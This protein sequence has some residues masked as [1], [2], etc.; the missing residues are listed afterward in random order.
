MNPLSCSAVFLS[1]LAWWKAAYCW[2]CVTP[3]RPALCCGF[4]HWS[5]HRVVAGTAAADRRT[6]HPPFLPPPPHRRSCWENPFSGLRG[7]TKWGVLVNATSTSALA[8]CEG[9]W[10]DGYLHGDGT[11]LCHSL[12]HPDEGHVVVQIIDGTLQK[13]DKSRGYSC[14]SWW[15]E[16]QNYYNT[17]NNTFSSK[18]HVDGIFAEKSI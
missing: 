18:K 14:Q 9:L 16:P 17:Q 7:Q 8:W 6:P 11:F 2:W 3:T 10:V 5:A 1:G 4:Q 13:K 12:V 15:S